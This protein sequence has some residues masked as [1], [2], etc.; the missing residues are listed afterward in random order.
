MNLVEAL[1]LSRRAE[2]YPGLILHGADRDLRVA[3]AL[4]LARALLCEQAA[5]DRPCNECKHCRRIEAPEAG[6]VTF[7]P[8]FFLVE[9]DL[10]TATSVDAVKTMLRAAQMRPF[11][12]RGQV[13]VLADAQTLAPSAADALLKNLEEPP[14]SAPRHFLLLSPSSVELLPTLRSR[15]LSIYLGGSALDPEGEL[16]DHIEPLASAIDSFAESG[17]PV[18]LLSAARLLFQASSWDDPRSATP[19]S[20]SAWLVLQVAKARAPGELRRGLL[21][22]CEELLDG[23]EL[24]V[25]NV[26]AP[27]I[28]EGVLARGLAS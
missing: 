13:F 2:L 12:A 14:V 24:R 28:L 5:E 19:W 15:C 22:V 20:Q 16:A 26:P 11:E 25:R 3:A 17:S 8:D 21:R 27:R 10:R 1:E 7:H 4:D 18:L 6:S 9:R 23:I